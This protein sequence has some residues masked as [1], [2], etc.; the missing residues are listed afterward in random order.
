MGNLFEK[1]IL[2]L[3]DIKFMF[4]KAL[5]TEKYNSL[6]FSFRI[7]KASKLLPSINYRLFPFI[8]E[9]CTLN[10]CYPFEL[11]FFFALRLTDNKFYCQFIKTTHQFV[12]FISEFLF[13]IDIFFD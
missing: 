9:F 13:T 4:L 8:S 3:F 7:D 12:L 6:A 10:R 2:R 5:I 1:R 11:P